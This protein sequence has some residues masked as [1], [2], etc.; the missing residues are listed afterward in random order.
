MSN[1]VD[2]AGFLTFCFTGFGPKSG[3]LRRGTGTLFNN[4]IGSGLSSDQDHDMPRTVSIARV[5]FAAERGES[6]AKEGNYSLEP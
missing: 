2:K 5:G 3:P 4:S 6:I 1:F